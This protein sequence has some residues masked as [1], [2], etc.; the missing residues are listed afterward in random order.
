MTRRRDAMTDRDV[1]GRRMK[2]GEHAA[3]SESERTENKT[4]L[5]EWREVVESV[6]AFATSGGGWVRIGIGPDG[7]RT[8]VRLGRGTLED[9]ANKIKVNTDPAQFPSIAIEGSDDSAV[10]TIRME[11][12]PIKPVWAFGRPL[13]RVGRT[14]QHVSREQAQRM[15]ETTTG[16]TWDAMACRGFQADEMERKAVRDYL[17]RAGLAARAAQTLLKNLALLTPEGATCNGAALLFARHPQQFFPEAQVK[18]ARFVGTTSVRFLDEQTLDGNL[19][20]QMDQALAFVARNT[21]QGIRITGRAERETIAEYPEEAVREAL[22]NALCHRDY[23]AVGTVQVRIYDNRLEVWNPGVLPPELSIESLSREHPSRPRNPR[24][25][26]ALYRARLIEHWGT[27][28]LRMI[29][30]AKDQG[31][32]LEFGEDAGVF[33]ARFIGA[34]QVV[35]RPDDVQVN[36]RQE[37]VLRYLAEHGTITRREYR[38]LFHVSERQSLRDLTEMMG[39]GMVIRLGG[40]HTT[41][42]QLSTARLVRD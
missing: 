36:V 11:E 27:G 1:D 18:C 4:S 29:R 26:Q 30:A 10:V 23:A 40:G 39:K 5:A 25:A 33:M 15:T 20:S 32:K 28:T 8:G 34:A 24:L 21:R 37:K 9:L 19:L 3:S 2:S 35:S 17:G 31:M 41:R 42:Y 13:K 6:A 14:N 22:V 38:S 16:R 7:R 12:S